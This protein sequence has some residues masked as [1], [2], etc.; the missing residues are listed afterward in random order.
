MSH[1][2]KC[3]SLHYLCKSVLDLEENWNTESKS[4]KIELAQIV[5]PFITLRDKTIHL[6]H[7]ILKYIEKFQFTFFY[8]IAVYTLEL[9]TNYQFKTD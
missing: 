7:S 9:V 8:D 2:K 3:I 6:V 1:F 4:F 5:S